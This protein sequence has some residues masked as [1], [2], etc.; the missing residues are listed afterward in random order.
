MRARGRTDSPVSSRWRAISSGGLTCQC[1]QH[2][3]VFWIRPS[4]SIR[5]RRHCPAYRGR[6]HVCTRPTRACLSFKDSTCVGGAVHTGRS[7]R[8]SLIP[9]SRVFQRPVRFRLT[10]PSR[11]PQPA[12]AGRPPYA[13]ESNPRVRRQRLLMNHERRPSQLRDGKLR[14]LQL[15]KHGAILIIVE[16]TGPLWLM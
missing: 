13:E 2:A 12:A 11:K 8:C 4:N 5:A 1:L 6:T 7:T 16:R 10:P 3:L 14:S 15:K 9:A